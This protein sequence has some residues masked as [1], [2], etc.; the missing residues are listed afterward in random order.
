MPNLPPLLRLPHAR[1][2]TLSLL[3]HSQ[4]RRCHDMAAIW[5]RVPAQH[6]MF[7]IAGI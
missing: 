2:D 5:L 4:A 6:W 7:T 3:S 1:H